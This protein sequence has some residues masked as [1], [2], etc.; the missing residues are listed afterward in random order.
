MFGKRHEIQGDNDRGE[1]RT[2]LYLSQKAVYIVVNVLD[3][4][5]QGIRK[6]ICAALRGVGSRV[7][8]MNSPI[9][10]TR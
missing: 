4:K 7:I 1:T 3:T 2:K 10:Y 6:T 9:Q 5:S 8:V